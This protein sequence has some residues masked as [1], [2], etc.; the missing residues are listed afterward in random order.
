MIKIYECERI[1]PHKKLS[2]MRKKKKYSNLKDLKS[3]PSKDD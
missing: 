3:M 1:I 2:G